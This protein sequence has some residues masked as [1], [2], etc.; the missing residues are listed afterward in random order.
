MSG[1]PLPMTAMATSCVFCPALADGG[2]KHQQKQS[3]WV[4]YRMGDILSCLIGHPS[5]TADYAFFH[6]SPRRLCYTVVFFQA[7]PGVHTRVECPNFEV[8]H[9][10]TPF[11]NAPGSRP[12]PK[13]FVL[14]TNGPALSRERT[15]ITLYRQSMDVLAVYSSSGFEL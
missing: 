12:L 13:V 11:S 6:C 3:A 5:D 8:I 10:H 7:L 4:S 15:A 2:P 9:I 1:L 14:G